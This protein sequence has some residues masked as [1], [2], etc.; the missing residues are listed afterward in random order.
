MLHLEKAFSIFSLAP[1]LVQLGSLAA[2][3]CSLQGCVAARHYDEARSVAEA[4]TAAHGRTRARLEAA[5]ERVRVLEGDLKGKEQTLAQRE[6][7]VAQSKLDTTVAQKEREAAAMLVEQLRS[8][9]AR[10]GDHLS[11]SSRE[12]RDLQQTLLIAEQRM[13][14]IEAAGKKLELLV[15]ATRDLALGLETPL[16]KE[17]VELGAKDGQVVVSIPAE[18]LFVAESETLQPDALP[19]LSAVGKVSAAHPE[20][21]VLVREPAGAPFAA[22]R[23]KNLGA[24]LRER[25]VTDARLT[26]CLPVAEAGAS[27]S[28]ATADEGGGAS[29]P[30]EKASESEALDAL[31]EKPSATKPK[32]ARV[33]DEKSLRYEIAF[34]P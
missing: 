32:A 26:L 24:A 19:V 6:S 2:L 23:A 17:R 27:E 12:K 30:G 22:G 11:S 14:G 31:A 8:E 10:T 28:P 29:V 1:R 15:G 5:L 18:K 20:L 16:D 7:D 34:A 3:G 21:R 33:A 4:E 13:Q 9:L 25:G